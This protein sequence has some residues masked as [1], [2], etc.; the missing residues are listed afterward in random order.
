M[1][2]PWV[3][4]PG[5]PRFAADWV[6]VGLGNPGEEY[7]R[8]R[9][10][11]GFWVIDELARRAGVRPRVVGS[12]MA[13]AVGQLAGSL[14]ALVKP[15]TYVNRSG[16]AVVQALAWT[17]VPRA[18]LIVVHDDLD[19]EVG[20]LRVRFG[21]GHGGHNGLRSIAAAVGLDFVRVRVGIGRPTV[22][23]R[24]TWDPDVVAAYVLSAPAPG[25]AEEL[26][27]AVRLAADAVETVVRDGVEA[28]AN[29]YNR[30][31]SRSG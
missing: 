31:A 8:H 28:A 11:V 6:V 17:G 1:R 27:A 24:S 14:V 22:E 5:T 2:K 19:L 12:T 10:N 9:H 29:R 16:D 20:A 4:A 23:G 15:R 13:I 3:R 18:R 30:R 25:E 7:A 21:G 26:K